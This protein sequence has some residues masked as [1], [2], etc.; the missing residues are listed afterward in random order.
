M[1]HS[2]RSN[3]PR[4]MTEAIARAQMPL[5]FSPM[6]HK[7][8]SGGLLFG[9]SLSLPMRIGP[10]WRSPR[11]ARQLCLWHKLRTV[12]RVL[13]WRSNPL[14]GI[15]LGDNLDLQSKTSKTYSLAVATS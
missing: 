12:G 2:S 9:V 11:G 4:T 10:S 6:A 13:R 3:I 8:E 1:S 14:P 7:M 5:G 15:S